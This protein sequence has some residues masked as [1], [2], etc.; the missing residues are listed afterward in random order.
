MTQF[1]IKN[2]KLGVLVLNAD[3]IH[4]PVYYIESN[5]FIRSSLQTQHS[6]II[7]SD[8]SLVPINCRCGTNCVNSPQTVSASNKHDKEE[9]QTICQGLLQS[10]QG[11]FSRRLPVCKIGY[12]KR[13]QLG[14]CRN[15]MRPCV[16]S[17]MF[18]N[19]APAH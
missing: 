11:R 9:N 15:Y 2:C 4:Y 14:N 17:H 3:G 10:P 1:T 6:P 13:I 8:W 12:L 5:P 18:V 7:K 19:K 16:M